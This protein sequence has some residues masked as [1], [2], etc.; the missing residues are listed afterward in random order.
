MAT[1][2]SP[3][4]SQSP[5]EGPEVMDGLKTHFQDLASPTHSLLLLWWHLPLHHMTPVFQHLLTIPPGE[6]ITLSPGEVARA[7]ES[8]TINKAPR[9]RL[10]TCILEG[11]SSFY[12]WPISL[13]PYLPLDT[14]LHPFAWPHNTHPHRPC[15][16]LRDLSSYRGISLLSFISKV[17]EKV[18]INIMSPDI[19]LNPLQGGLRSRYSCL[20]TVYICKM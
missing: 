7:V 13:M 3:P 1:K 20:H 9:S 16:D 2:R 4:L 8:L 12:I 18:L 10:S 5:E 6:D 11:P 17:L 19:S 14:S 15:R